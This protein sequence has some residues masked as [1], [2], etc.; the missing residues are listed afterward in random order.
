[1]RAQAGQPAEN[2][3][4]TAQLMETANFGI[5]GAEIGQEVAC[6]ATVVTNRV[7]VK[8]GADGVNRTS[9]PLGQRM[10][11]RRAACTIHDGVTGSGRMCWATARAYCW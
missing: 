2:V 1:M 6:G 8:C 4:I 10:L 5:V 9:E 3:W 7:R 11:K